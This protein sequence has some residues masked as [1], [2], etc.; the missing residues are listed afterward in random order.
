M[1]LDEFSSVSFFFGEL[2]RYGLVKKMR[3]G[4]GGN[5]LVYFGI[6]LCFC[7]CVM[8]MGLWWW[9]CQLD[10]WKGWFDVLYWSW[11]WYLR[12]VCGHG[13]VQFMSPVM[14][15]EFI[16]MFVEERISDNWLCSFDGCVDGAC[17][18]LLGWS[19][20]C[21]LNWRVS[22]DIVCLFL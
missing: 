13:P 5:A 22:D 20:I 11:S 7:S 9:L 2:I 21:R 8:A 10:Y 14:C 15:A 19:M 1:S 18:W 4:C 16:L 6:S 3:S 17:S 12:R